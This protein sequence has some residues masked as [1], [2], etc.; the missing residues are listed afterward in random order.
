MKQNFTKAIAYWLGVIVVGLS[1]GLALQFVRAWTEPTVAPPG[2][3]VGAP[4]NTSINDQAKSGSLVINSSGKPVG[5]LVQGSVGIGTSSPYALLHIVAPDQGPWALNIRNATATVRGLEIFQADNGKVHFSS[6]NPDGALLT[7]TPD[8]KVG[9]GTD[10]PSQRL[11]VGG[12]KAQADDFCLNSDPTKCLSSATSDHCFTYECSTPTAFGSNY[13]INPRCQDNG[14]ERGYCPNGYKQ[15]KA[16]GAYGLCKGYG[17][18]VDYNWMYPPGGS[19]NGSRSSERIG[20][21]YVC[22]AN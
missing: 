21:A 8:G 17:S 19:C 12:G 5:L 13:V 2:G 9:V 10:N 4:L 7:M 16:L 6:N 22:C 1:L 18:A 15:K 3:N 11:H 14:G 20:D